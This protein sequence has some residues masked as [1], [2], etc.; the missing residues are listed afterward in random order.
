[1]AI[2]MRRPVLSSPSSLLKGNALIVGRLTLLKFSAVFGL[3]R[4]SA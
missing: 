2:V 4:N 1:V 3:S